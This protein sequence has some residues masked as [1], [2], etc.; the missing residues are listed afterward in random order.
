MRRNEKWIVLACGL[1]IAIVLFFGWWYIAIDSWFESWEHRKPR[2]ARA[3]QLAG[4]IIAA[5]AQYESDNGSP[6]DSFQD[7]L[8]EYLNKVPK[9]GLREH[10]QFEYTRFSEA[11]Q[12][13]IWYDLGSRNGK[14]ISGLCLN[15]DGDHAHAILALTLD[16][17]DTVVHARVDRM[18]EDYEL[19]DFNLEKWR[20]GINRIEMVESLSDYLHL[21][22]VHMKGVHTSVLQEMLGPSDGSRTLR[23]SPWE[24]RINCSWGWGINWDVFFYWPTERY[25]KYIYGGS[26]EPIGNWVYVHE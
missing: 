16:H 5:I 13:L 9:T 21:K 20:E 23:D 26:T 4:P 22:G 11:K 19:M 7:L 8:P 24:L 18:P 17:N 10:P 15:D 1:A 2:F 25:P 12:S 6:P 3:A 14:P